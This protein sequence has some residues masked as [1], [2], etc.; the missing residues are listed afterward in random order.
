MF[1][2]LRNSLIEE[3]RHSPAL[4]SDLAG[5]EDYVAE[6]YDARAFTEL[7]QNA[8]DADARQ[9]HISQQGRYLIVANDGAEFTAANLEALCRSAASSKTRGKTIGYRGIGFKSVVRLANEVSLISGD[10][11]VTF[12]RALTM[13]VVP[14]ADRVPLIR[15]PHPIAPSLLTHVGEYVDRLRGEGYTTVFVFSGIAQEAIDNEFAQLDHSVLLFLRKV[16]RLALGDGKTDAVAVTRTAQEDGRVLA[17]IRSAAGETRWNVFHDVAVAFAFACDGATDGIKPLERSDAVV[18]AFLPTHEETGIGA[19]INGDFST[20]PSRTRVV[21][22]KRTGERLG[23]AAKLFVNLLLAAIGL[24]G[25]APCAGVIDA[26]VPS[27]DPRVFELQRKSFKGELMAAVKARW[28]EVGA[29]VVL[30]PPWLN[31]VDFEPLARRAGVTAIPKD[32]GEVPHARELFRY[33]GVR[34]MPIDSLLPAIPDAEVSQQGCAELLAT[35]IKLADTKQMDVGDATAALPLLYCGGAR[36]SITDAGATHATADKDFLDMVAECGNGLGGLRRL[37]RATLGD[38]AA[39]KLLSRAEETTGTAAAAAPT[40]LLEH[41]R[42]FSPATKDKP[43][44]LS[45]RKW[46]NAEEQVAGILEAEGLTATDVSRQN[47]GYD[48][49]CHDDQGRRLFVEVKSVDAVGQPFT[50]TS[51]EEAVART[52]GADYVLAIVRQQHSTVEVA[53]IPDPTNSVSMIRQCRQWV[54]ECS[55]YPFEPRVY[56]LQ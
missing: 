24:Q 2:D 33:L 11:R 38:K 30:R 16:E 55:S 22:D 37:A 48:I 52:K 13:K 49:E 44:H 51:N 50:M 26:L 53:F 5:L 40:G 39:D 1:D 29:D 20:D 7:L 17:S 15:I 56:E 35:L 19:K 36:L 12:S 46:R 42:T 27:D 4:L 23:D 10:Y 28:L 32:A 14:E 45:I 21:L 18:H 43:K 31:A 25:R 41:L 9:F 8:D 47:V 54:W 6:S 3:A 34:D